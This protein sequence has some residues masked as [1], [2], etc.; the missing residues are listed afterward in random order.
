MKR[1][2]FLQTCS[3]TALALAVPAP[4]QG[5][6]VPRLRRATRLIDPEHLTTLADP[7]VRALALDAVEAARHAGAR[8]ADV[9]LTNTISRNLGPDSA[10]QTVT[11]ELGVRALV[12]GY[13][14]FSSTPLLTVNHG[15]AIRVARES[16][17]MATE[18]ATHGRPRTVELGT[19]PVVANGTWAT[20]VAIDP[21][22]VKDT[23]IIDWMHGMAAYVRDIGTSRGGAAFIAVN[24]S[25]ATIDVAFGRQEQVFASTEGSFI[26]Q[27][28]TTIFPRCNFNYQGISSG[29]LPG[30][31]RT[32]QGGWEMFA[33]RSDDQFR[34]LIRT[35]M[36][37]MDNDLR[38]SPSVR[39]AIVQPGRY[40]LV[41][42]ANAMAS[43]LSLTLGNATEVDRA[44]G[45]EANATGTSY[46]GPDP[47]RMLGAPVASPLVTVTAER[48]TPTA[49]ATITWDDEGVTPENFTLV[50]A[51]VLVDYQTTREQASWLTP[52]YEKRGQPVR[53]HGCASAPS[54]GFVAMQ[55]TPNLHLQ[56]GT[57]D[58]ELADM[59][60][61]LE[62]GLV[63]Y[64]MGLQ[65][66]MQC[67]NGV[68]PLAAVEV[69]NGRQ[70]AQLGQAAILFKA[71]EFWKSVTALGGGKSV[72]WFD[73]VGLGKGAPFQ[74]TTYSVSAVPALVK[75]Q[76][77]IDY[78]RKA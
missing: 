20:P 64:G 7:R 32:V 70:I 2:N 29:P 1:R 46:L 39:Q 58:L 8:Y 10:T 33:Q 12:D 9:R 34:E 54:A 68:G 43:V 4:R 44:L 49:A 73:G 65:M 67:S 37:R 28:V 30:Y 62:H 45:Y 75:Q 35:T 38:R 53:S 23:E 48:S 59:I 78:T 61:G 50:K 3:T 66:D 16:V 17:R 13:W 41:L 77:V 18:A 15:E 21:F 14:G 40:D 36:D 69:R 6:R 25:G 24:G 26:L 51:G 11:L 72:D 52:W 71:S 56:P 27:T 31:N 57:A 42:T 76:A 19:I 74:T 60:G 55:H 47:L 63:I 22:T 5:L